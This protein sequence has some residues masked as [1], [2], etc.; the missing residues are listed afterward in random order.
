MNKLL[1]F[2]SM[3]VS[4]GY[5]EQINASN[6]IRI[7]LP[8]FKSSV[9]TVNVGDTLSCYYHCTQADSF[10][11]WN[12]RYGSGLRLIDQYELEIFPPIKV[13][14]FKATIA[15]D[16]TISFKEPKKADVRVQVIDNY[17][18]PPVFEDNQETW[19]PAY[20][21]FVIE[22][23]IDDIIPPRYNEWALFKHDELELVNYDFS[24]TKSM[25]KKFGFQSW[26]FKALHPG[27]YSISFIRNGEI[28]TVSVYAF[29]DWCGTGT[30]IT[31]IITF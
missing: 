29:D 16:Y 11:E 3:I 28:K 15:G 26:T 31:P 13:W 24:I 12:P 17:P 22:T 7:D 18:A 23:Q 14:I 2:L 8:Q 10:V 19:V 25:F 9:V 5:I 1:L 20:R 30:R 6:D 27:T 21:D 4:F